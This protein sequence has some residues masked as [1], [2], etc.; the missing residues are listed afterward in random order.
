[1]DGARKMINLYPDQMEI[2]DKVRDAMRSHKSVLLQSP[3]GSGKTKMA[4][5]MLEAALA[6]GK[7]CL[8]TV[9]RRDLMNQTSDSFEGDG[10]LHGYVAASREYNPYSRVHIGMIDTMAR[11]L[12]KLP[13]K[14]IIFIDETHFGSNSLNAVIQHYKSK[15]AWVLGL[16]ATPWKLSGEGLGKWYDHMVEGKSIKWLIDNKRLSDYRYFYGKTKPDLS[17]LDV[18]AGDYAKGQL[19]DF[20]EH[21]GAI[22]GDCVSDYR[23]RC[24]GRLHIVRCASI[25]HSQMLSQTFRDNGIPAMHVDGET[26]DDQRKQIFKAFARREILVLTFCDLLTFGFDLS[27][28][29][30]MDVCIE[31]CSDMRPSKSLAGQM[32]YWGRALR[33]KDYPAIINDHVN[34]YIDHL[35]PCTERVWTLESRKQGK[36]TGEKTLP[37]RQCPACFFVHNPAPV[38]P[39]CDHVYEIKGREIDEMDGELVEMDKDAIKAIKKQE[40]MEQGK[41]STLDDLIAIGIRKNY[42]NPTAWASRVMAGRMMKNGSY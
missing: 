40:R 11:R 17:K 39:N 8:F 19:A 2:V 21:Q 31:S 18:T 38:C 7:R 6:K 36:K 9:P 22:I 5:Y 3:T 28:A 14:D 12:D 29:S 32:Q 10:V 26:P 4:V 15:G 13:D 33:Y 42:K 20:M 27:Q 16:S 41:A 24:M 1:M 35:L 23:L 30:G 25:K 37:T 34:N